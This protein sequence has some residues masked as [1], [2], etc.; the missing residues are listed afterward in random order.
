[1][2]EVSAAMREAGQELT[3]QGVSA[4]AALERLAA[5]PERWANLA[6]EQAHLLAARLKTAP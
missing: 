4:E 2:R 1:M 3:R 6:R 5:E